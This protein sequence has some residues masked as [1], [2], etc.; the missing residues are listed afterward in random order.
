M[1]FA[2]KFTNRFTFLL[3]PFDR[4]NKLFLYFNSSF[5]DKKK[6]KKV[7]IPSRKRRTSVHA[8][9]QRGRHKG[10]SAPRSRNLRCLLSGATPRPTRTWAERGRRFEFLTTVR[11]LTTRSVAISRETYG[12][13]PSRLVS[14]NNPPS[15]ERGEGRGRGGKKS[16]KRGVT[17]GW[18]CKRTSL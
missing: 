12:R 7:S 14:K 3:Q 15:W 16:Q 10:R 6:K 11:V 2:L 4:N 1:F 17:R 5:F 13:G 9:R 18:Q 8:Q